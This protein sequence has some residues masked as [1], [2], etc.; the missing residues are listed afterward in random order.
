MSDSSVEILESERSGRIVRRSLGE[1]WH[2]IASSRVT[3]WL[4]FLVIF[5]Y[6]AWGVFPIVPIENDGMR[7]ALGIQYEDLYGSNEYA[8]RYT[9][10]AG[11]H[12]LGLALHRLGGI[13]PFTGL[14]ILAVVSSTIFVICSSGFLARVTGASLSLAIVLLLLFQEVFVSAYYPNS[15]I[16]AAAFLAAALL[17]STYWQNPINVLLAGVLFAFAVWSRFDVILVGL[18]F[19][20]LLTERNSRTTRNIALFGISSVLAGLLLFGMSGISLQML[21]DEAGS[22]LG[23]FGV[24]STLNVYST[25]FTLAIVYFIGI[26]LY[27]LLTS[28]K[29]RLLLLF[30]VPLPLVFVY[31]FNTYSPKYLLYCVVFFAVPLVYGIKELIEK[32]N[33]IATALLVIGVV[34]FAGQYVFTPAYNLI[35]RSMVVPTADHL[36]LRGAIAYT[37]IYWHDQKEARKTDFIGLKE[38]VDSY[39]SEEDPAYLFSNDWMINQWLM[40]YFLKKGFQVNQQDTYVEVVE[41]GQRLILMKNG[42]VVRLVRWLPDKPLDLPDMLKDEITSAPS[43]L[44]IGPS[45]ID[46]GL[47][48]QNVEVLTEKFEYV[49]WTGTGEF[50]LLRLRH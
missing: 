14:S 3:Q 40:Y 27:Q 4:F 6:L 33:R 2:L 47:A 49:S 12:Y 15:S 26:G 30:F 10:S 21:L 29:Y 22:N 41:H 38:T 24:R 46:E 50:R 43:L 44:Y 23:R 17:L 16:I 18:G 19:L 13:D 9:S 20:S 34:L 32:R 39:I 42:D 7:T 48:M 36:R 11:T 25:I 37:P 35:G 45:Y 5:G 1:T 28:K 31:G 8:Y